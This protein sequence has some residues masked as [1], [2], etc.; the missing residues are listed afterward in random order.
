[1]K[2]NRDFKKYH[3]E[4]D[5]DLTEEQLKQLDEA[6]NE[7]DNGEIISWEEFKKEMARWLAKPSKK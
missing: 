5:E 3:D 6:I 4:E 1:M 7:A 2:S